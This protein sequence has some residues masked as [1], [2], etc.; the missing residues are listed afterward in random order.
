MRKLLIV[1]ATLLIVVA[2][3]GPAVT[4][5]LIENAVSGE[6][7]PLETSLPPWLEAVTHEYQ[8]GW[9]NA[10]SNMRLVI[11]D[12]QRAATF[13]NFLGPGEFGDQPAL[14]VVSRVAHG[15]LVGI[16]TPAAAQ[17]NSLLFTENQEGQSTQ[18]PLAAVTTFGLTGNMRT[19][20]ALAEGGTVTPRGGPTLSWTDATGDYEATRGGRAEAATFNIGS[21]SFGNGEQIFN[22]I[23]LGYVMTRSDTTTSMAADFAFDL[24]QLGSP[25]N[26]IAGSVGVDDVPSAVLRNLSPLLRD[27]AA[28]GPANLPTL[29]ERNEPLIRAALVLPLPLRWRQVAGTEF[30]DIRVQFDIDLPG[31][32]TIGSTTSG[33]ALLAGIAAGTR[34]DGR[35]ELPT[36]FADAIGVT[37]PGLYEQL[38]ML[39]GMG[40]LAPDTT[41]DLL[42]MVVD[43][44]GGELT[45]NGA[46]VPTPLAPR[47]P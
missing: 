37:D 42:T 9:F 15:P 27:F 36:A 44:S 47:S 35:V 28:M 7:N 45:V 41:G 24:K 8:R 46:P 6:G 21:I 26:R 32:D 34:V 5:R 14:T 22:N 30:G 40:V 10:S 1:V 39:R 38:T 17:I 2:L 20:W 43:Y 11:T 3:A 29:A 23:A 31:N 4:G 16:F 12:P 19:E 25:I 33:Q 13:G 18:L